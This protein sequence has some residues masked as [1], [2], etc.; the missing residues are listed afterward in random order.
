M[1]AAFDEMGNRMF[2]TGSDFTAENL[3]PLHGGEELICQL[4]FA[5]LMPGRY[6]LKLYYNE[7]A[8]GHYWQSDIPAFTI[9]E[10]DFYGTGQYPGGRHGCFVQPAKWSKSKSG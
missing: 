4:P 9:A 7:S 1:I 6:F 2:T 10:T 3:L 8:L 5:P